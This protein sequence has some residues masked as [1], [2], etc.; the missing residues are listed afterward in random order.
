MGKKT[1]K[2]RLPPLKQGQIDIDK[3]RITVYPS[4]GAGAFGYVCEC[5]DK[6]HAHRLPQRG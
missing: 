2:Q 3:Y 5:L 6:K 4:I 1:S